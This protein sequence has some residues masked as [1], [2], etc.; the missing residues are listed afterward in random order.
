ML[1]HYIQSFKYH[2]NDIILSF[3]SGTFLFITLKDVPIFVTILG[4]L[5]GTVCLPL[6]FGWRRYKKQEEREQETALIK[7]IKDL[8][9]LGFINKDEPIETQRNKSMEWL[10]KPT[11]N[12]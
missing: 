6:Y 1:G 9:D 10:S 3:S 11:K 4:T 2:I 8:R 7:A 5:L 12:I